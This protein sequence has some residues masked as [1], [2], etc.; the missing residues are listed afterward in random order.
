MLTNGEHL[1]ELG[2]SI[3]WVSVSGA[4]HATTP[5][6]VLHGGPG[7]Q[8]LLYERSAGPLINRERTLVLHEQRG[9]GRSPRTEQVDYSIPELVDDVCRVI[10]RIGEPVDLL[11]WSFGGDLAARVAL[12]HPGLVNR[13][14]L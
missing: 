8:N 9:C 2:E 3:Q 6:L 1:L 14:V 11:G 13:L 7:A 10:D 12:D 5:L 4:E